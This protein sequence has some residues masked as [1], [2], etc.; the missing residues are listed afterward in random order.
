MLGR[1]VKRALDVTL[2][3]AGLGLLL[4]FYPA[5]AAAVRLDSPGP[6]RFRH[7]RLGELG[8]EIVVVKLR[9]MFAA[10]GD[11]YN[12]DGSRR[13]VRD[14]DARLTRVGRLLR[15]G[16]DELPQLVGVV[17]GDLSLVGPRPDDLYAVGLYRDAE[18]LKLSVKPGLT[19]LAAV[20][21]RNDLPWRERLRYDVY[22]AQHRSLGLDLRILW[23]TIGLALR[24][25]R[26]GDV[27]AP[28]DVARFAASP[29]AAAAGRLV[30]AEVRR[31][32]A[33]TFEEHVRPLRERRPPA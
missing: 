29:E 26:P 32:L 10:A 18:W 21:G 30:E 8:R 11:Q 22:Y 9:T 28:D 24:L 1:A 2:A 14:G 16:I 33:G 27:I 3:A 5:V 4:P 12:P 31:R 7:R 19:G 6:A 15:G 20:S 23:K 25:T 13:E 17:R